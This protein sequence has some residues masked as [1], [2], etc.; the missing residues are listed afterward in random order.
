MT[1]AEKVQALKERQA[2]AIDKLEKEE[3]LRAILPVQTEH[4]RICS[5]KDHFSITIPTGEWPRRFTI[6]EIMPFYEQLKPHLVEIVGIRDGCLS[7]RPEALQDRKVGE[8]GAKLMFTAIAELK[9]N[10]G[11][12]YDA[13]EMSFWIKLGETFVDVQLE[14]QPPHQLIP[15]QVYDERR[16]RF[17]GEFSSP[18]VGADN[19]IKWWSPEESYMFGHWWTTT[20]SFE[21]WVAK[22]ITPIKPT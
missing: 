16:G 13:H 5:H 19:T 12:G 2:E 10:A 6:A 17:Y 18:Q 3:A 8:S 22:Q 4:T 1:T 7:V 21:K 11:K 15:R 20:E 14:L 9:L